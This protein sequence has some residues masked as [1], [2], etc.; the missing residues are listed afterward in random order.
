[1]NTTAT[2]IKQGTAHPYDGA[3]I[4]MRSMAASIQKQK[5]CEDNVVYLKDVPL[6]AA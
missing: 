1:M 6:K 5:S 4:A 3:A 2:H